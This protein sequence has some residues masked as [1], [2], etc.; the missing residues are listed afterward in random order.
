[1]RLEVD[2]WFGVLTSVRRGMGIA[3]GPRAC[4]DETLFGDLAVAT[5]GGAPTWQ[6]GVATRDEALRG[7]AGRAFL[8]AYRRQ[9]RERVGG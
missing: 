4:V 2:E 3:C 9:C 5:L 1:V 7:A 8:D 6:L